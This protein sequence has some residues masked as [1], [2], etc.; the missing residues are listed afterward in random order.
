MAFEKFSS[1]K[2]RDEEIVCTTGKPA[3]AVRQT[4]AYDLRTYVNIRKLNGLLNAMTQNESKYLALAENHTERELSELLSVNP[5]EIRRY[6]KSTGVKP[7]PTCY[8]NHT[9]EWYKSEFDKQ[10]AGKLE[11]TSEITRGPGGHP[12][13]MCRCLSCGTQW[14]TDIAAKL[15]TKNGCVKCDKGNHGNRYNEKTVTDMLNRSYE[16]QWKLIQYGHYSK[17]DSVIQCQLCGRKQIVKLDDFIN[18]TTKRCTFCQTGSFGEY[19]ISNTLLYNGISFTREAEVCIEGHKYRIDFIINNI[20][21]EYSG[22]QHFEKGRYYNEAINSG[23]DIK[24]QW[25]KANGYEF[26]EMHEHRYMSDIIKHLSEVLDTELQ[27]PTPEFFARNYPDMKTVLSYMRTHS[28]RATHTRL[29]VPITKIKK[30]VYLAGY[31]SIS[32]WQ[33]DNKL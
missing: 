30:Y 13:A 33:A 21:L 25:A 12:K 27:T 20:A 19:V 4:A 2:P 32:A 17:K 29:N 15:R 16:N 28:A 26:V 6:A 9:L 10:Y 8:Q 18:T 1:R 31:P 23:V 7:K 11:L 14:R 5:R 24:R 22:R 3:A